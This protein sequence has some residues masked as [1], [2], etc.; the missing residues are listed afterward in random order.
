MFGSLEC[1]TLYLY[2]YTTDKPF[3]MLAKYN[4]TEI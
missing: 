2:E 1:M 3:K 4:A